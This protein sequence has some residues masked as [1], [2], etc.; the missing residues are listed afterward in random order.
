M[1]PAITLVLT[2]DQ[3]RQ[4]ASAVASLLREEQSTAPPPMLGLDEAA[5]LAGVTPRTISNW[6]SRGRL[7]RYGVPRRPLVARDELLA[8][9]APAPI[10]PS[11]TPRVPSGPP[12][13]R[14]PTG[15]FTQLAREQQR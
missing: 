11:R 4:I 1:T 6:I 13:R 12:R 8:L 7:T 15:H 2:D 9:L 10:A 3:L 5:A 14:K